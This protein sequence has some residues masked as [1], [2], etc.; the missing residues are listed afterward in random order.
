MK[1]RL[2]YLLSN[3]QIDN[4]KSRVLYLLSNRQIDH[5]KSRLLHLLSNRQIDHLKSRVIYLLS[6]RQI[7][8]LKSRLLYLLSNVYILILC[9]TCVY[10]TSVHPRNLPIY[11]PPSSFINL[12][13]LPH[14]NTVPLIV[15]TIHICIVPFYLSHSLF[16]FSLLF[17]LSFSN[18]LPRSL[19]FSF[20][21]LSSSGRS[22]VPCFLTS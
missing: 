6:N 13:S 10:R 12:Y 18:S 7:D 8:N 20:V 3:R 5:L 21:S 17:S 19:S 14:I 1:S 4:L 16:F 15:Y 11:H 2:V 9:V 22:P